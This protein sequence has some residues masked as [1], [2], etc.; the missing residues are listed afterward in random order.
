MASV[1]R[2]SGM[3]EYALLRHRQRLEEIE[4]LAWQLELARARRAQRDTRSSPISLRQR[5]GYRLMRIGARI[6]A[7]T[8]A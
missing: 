3:V 7:Q 4:A 8:G 2:G 6:A 1:G 5:I